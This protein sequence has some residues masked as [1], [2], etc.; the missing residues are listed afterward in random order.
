M[1]KF[2]PENNRKR[3]CYFNSFSS[4]LDGRVALLAT[5]TELMNIGI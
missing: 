5:R 2:N 4:L 3:S 1:Q